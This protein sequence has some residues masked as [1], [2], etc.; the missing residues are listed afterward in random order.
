MVNSQK[1][2]KSP[3]S[4]N[5]VSELEKSE[6]RLNRSEKIG[7]IGNYEYDL[8]TKAGFWSDQVYELYQ[9]DKSLGPPNDEEIVKYYSE[10][11][12]LRLRGYIVDVIETGKPVENYECLVKLPDGTAIICI[13]SMFPTLDDHGQV[14]K[15][16]GVLQD[17]TL[18]KEAQQKLKIQAQELQQLNYITSHNLKAPISNIHALMDLVVFSELSEQN[19]MIIDMIRSSSISMM[20]TIQ[21]LNEVVSTK[22]SFE[23]LPEKILFSNCFNI[24]ANELSVLVE[25]SKAVIS[26]DFEKVDKLF[27][28]RIHL[29]GIIQNL[30]SNAIKYRDTDRT[31]EIKLWSEKSSEGT[32]LIVSDNGLGIDLE[33]M[34]NKLFG[35]FQR[36]HIKQEGSGIGLYLVKSTIENYGGKVSVESE[37]GKGTKF[38]ILFKDNEQ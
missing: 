19:K 35:L 38:T 34:K 21:G 17:I 8:V 10:E 22:N 9:R 11:D 7:K 27:F 32:C 5:E 26:T 1:T 12:H 30:L 13:G 31:S 2:T 33:L 36:Y 29:V 28:P 4:P 18:Q 25:E 37:V 3:L 20:D 23:L 16:Y 24:A 15:I 6:L 14:V